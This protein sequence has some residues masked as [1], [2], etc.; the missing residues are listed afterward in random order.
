MVCS[1]IGRTRARMFIAG[2]TTAPL[3]AVALFA[4]QGPDP[5]L[6][7]RTVVLTGQPAPGQAEGVV[8]GQLTTP[9]NHALLVPR[10]DQAGRVAFQAM[11]AGPGVDASNF[12][13]MWADENGQLA[14]LARGGQPA[15]GTPDG[16]VFVGVP[17]LEVPF[18]PEFAGG[19][20]AFFATLAGPGVGILNDEG[21]WAGPPS[22]L[23]LVARED[24]PAPGLPG[25]RFG[26]PFARISESG[27][28]FVSTDLRGAGVSG[29]SNSSLWTDR[30]GALELVFREGAPAPLTEPGTIFGD[31]QNTGTAGVFRFVTF[32]DQANL[33]V[34]AR[35]IGPAVDSFNDEL[36]YVERDGALELVVRE[37]DPAPGLGHGVTVG[38]NSVSLL[39]QFVSLNNNGRVAF[40]AR[41]GGSASTQTAMFSDRGG[42]LLAEVAPGDP[43]PGTSFDFSFWGSPLLNNAN[44]IAFAAALPDNDG[45][46]FTPPPFGIWTDAGGALDAALLPGDTTTEGEVVTSAALA[47][48]NTAGQILTTVGIQSPTFRT[49]IALRTPAGDLRRVAF[50]GDL[51]DVSRDGQDM[52][53]VI[54]VINGGLNENG[55]IAFRLDFAGGSSGHFVATVAGAP[56][57]D[58]DGDGDV[59]LTDLALLLADFGCMT[60]GC[61]GDLD[62]DGDTDLTDLS[63]LLGSF[64][65]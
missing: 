64:G 60:G 50:I 29:T 59:D 48:F 8:F 43:A 9:L 25:V 37:G 16:V 28:V 22:A 5:Q 13:S 54:R 20:A 44:Q 23:R 30:S 39:L 35:V 31:T 4:G 62:G 65:S 40:N 26:F 45:D 55:A 11:L 34:V 3:G 41:L 27:V 46:P 58:L 15:P 63:L 53:E 47:G 14:L 36:L 61:A 19:Q 24:D 18:P 21:S 12:Q 52:R 33:A 42:A 10:I 17:S 1:F 51:F 56:A 2:L 32:D 7:Y 49:G 38:G 57:G 6:E